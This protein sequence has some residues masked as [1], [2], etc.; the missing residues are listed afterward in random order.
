MSV[1]STMQGSQR[2]RVVLSYLGLL[3]VVVEL[4]LCRN[5][6]PRPPLALL[7]RRATTTETF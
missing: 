3:W 1:F 6:A 7:G 5:E 4:R 2:Q